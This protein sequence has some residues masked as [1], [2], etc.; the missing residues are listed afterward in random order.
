MTSF[1]EYQFSQDAMLKLQCGNEAV[2]KREETGAIR[3]EMMKKLPK[4]HID[5]FQGRS[6]LVLTQGKES[7]WK[8]NAFKTEYPIRSREQAENPL[9]SMPDHGVHDKE[10]FDIADNEVLLTYGC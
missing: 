6:T 10:K 1:V 3:A 4:E 8:S 2:A 7:Q 5:T 9:W